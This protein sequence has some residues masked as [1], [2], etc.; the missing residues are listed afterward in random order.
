MSRDDTIF[1]LHRGLI[2]IAQVASL[3]QPL[4][5]IRESTA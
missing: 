5:N 4:R 3:C 2:S 1:V